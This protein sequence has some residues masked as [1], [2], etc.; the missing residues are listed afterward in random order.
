MCPAPF[1]IVLSIMKKTIFIITGLCILLQWGCRL[2]ELSVCSPD[3][4]SFERLYMQSDTLVVSDMTATSDGNFI[5]CGSIGDDIFLMKIDQEGNTIFFERDVIPVTSETCNAIAITPD[6]GFVTCGVQESRAYLAKYDAQG[7]HQNQNVQAE[8]SDCRCIVDEG[9]GQYI[10]SG[11]RHNNGIM[12]TYVAPVTFNNT[13]PAI[14]SGYLPTPPRSG[15]EAAQ[16]VLVTPSGYTVAGFSY[17]SMPPGNA[18]A[19]H[20]YRL[21]DNLNVVMGSEKFHHL[22]TQ[23]DIANDMI[24][25]PQGN[26]MIVGN[27][28]TTPEV[29]NGVDMFVL[30]VSQNGEILNQYSYGGSRKDVALNIIHAHQSG[31]YIVTGRS[32]SFGDSSEDFYV[33]KI[34]QDGSIVWQQT[35]GQPATDEVPAAVIRTGDCGYIIAG[36]STQNGQHRPYIIKID[37]VGNIQ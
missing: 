7:K 35:F 11:R 26:Y 5:I 33:S 3:F 27:F 8:V 31:Q 36:R 6:G 12:N 22:G 16:A 13:F 15:T 21:H 37:E 17:N 10:I 19:V 29:G 34:N 18:A 14:M 9:G 20:F 2:Q 32:Q 25:T 1:S 4:T 30:E 23:Q 24:Q 28:H